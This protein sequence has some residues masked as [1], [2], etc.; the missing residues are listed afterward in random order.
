MINLIKEWLRNVNSQK[1]IVVIRKGPNPEIRA[2]MY[3]L[4]ATSLR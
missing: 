1:F 2:L 4:V 3:Q